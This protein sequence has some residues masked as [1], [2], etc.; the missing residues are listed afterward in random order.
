VQVPVNPGSIAAV[1]PEPF[2]QDAFDG[3]EV[4][5]VEAGP[6]PAVISAN[7]AGPIFTVD[8]M[9]AGAAPGDVLDFHLVDMV[10]PWSGGQGGAFSTT[11]INSLDTGGDAVPDG[12]V[13]VFGVDADPSRP[14]PPA[15]YL[16]DYIDGPNGGGP[17]TVV[18]VPPGDLDGDGDVDLS[19]LGVL[20]ADYGC[21]APAAPCAGDTDGDGDT[22]LS[23]LG[24][25]LAH[26]GE[27]AP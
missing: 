26:F 11:G 23:D 8:I 3:P 5:Y 10:V 19:D 27:A 16:V 14:V 12:S 1:W 20:L 25:L 2:I 9:L 6:G 13:T 7:P 21:T 17:A 15:A 24:N 18:V 22:D 4:Q